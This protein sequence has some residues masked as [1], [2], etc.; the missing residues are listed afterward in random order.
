MIKRWWHQRKTPACNAVNL[1]D[2]P[3][4]ARD[5]RRAGHWVIL[6]ALILVHGGILFYWAALPSVPRETDSNAM[7]PVIRVE[8]VSSISS[9]AH[10]KEDRESIEVAGIGRLAERRKKP[11]QLHT[12]TVSSTYPPAQALA[13]SVGMLPED[14]AIHPVT[15]GTSYES[16]PAAAQTKHHTSLF[17]T[18]ERHI[19]AGYQAVLPPVRLK[20]RRLV[21]AKKQIWPEDTGHLS[22][23]FGKRQAR[24]AAQQSNLV[25]PKAKLVEEGPTILLSLPPKRALVADEIARH[26]SRASSDNKPVSKPSLERKKYEASVRAHLKLHR[27]NGGFGVGLVV[28]AFKLSRSGNVASTRILRSSGNSDLDD[29]A[30]RA[31]HRSAPYPKP[32][33]GLRTSSLRF[34]IPFRFE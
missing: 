31:I 8:F 12:E 25:S 30:L 29:M 6:G 2:F 22:P 32:P 7:R 4:P 27:P 19:A 24:Q 18:F 14:R 3:K 15:R 10:S 13:V 23:D 1:L 16:V 20:S 26:A 21:E 9:K 11:I 17:L 34:T 33:A 28:V 5:I